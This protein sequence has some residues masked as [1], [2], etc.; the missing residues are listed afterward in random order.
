VYLESSAAGNIN[1]YKRFGFQQE[2]EISLER[3]S[4]PLKLSIMVREPVS[5]TEATITMPPSKPLVNVNAQ[6][7]QLA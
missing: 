6:Q 2:R 7:A 4:P 3:S 1:F 5:V